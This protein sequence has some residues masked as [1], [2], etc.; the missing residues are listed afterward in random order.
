MGRNQLNIRLRFIEYAIVLL[1]FFIININSVNRADAPGG[2]ASSSPVDASQIQK[3]TSEELHTLVAP[4]ALYPD[5]LLAQILPASTFPVQIVVAYRFIQNGGKPD[6]PPADA[7][8]DSSV[9]ALLHYPTVLK[10]LNDD[11]KWT[12]QLGL[13]VTYQ[14]GDVSQ[15]IQQV[16]AE[17]SAAGNLQSNAMETTQNDGDAIEIVPAEPQLIYVPDYDPYA[18]C[19]GP[20]PN[21]FIW[22]P[23]FGFGIWLGN[24]WDWHHHHI[25]FNNYWDHGGW[26][27]NSRP[28]YWQAAT[29]PL[30][31]WYTKSGSHGLVGNRVSL[32]GFAAGA[33]ARAR[34]DPKATPHIALRPSAHVIDEEDA[35][36][37]GNQTHLESQRGQVSRNVIQQ[38][39]VEQ[40]V[41]R[42]IP[43]APQKP[44]FHEG[45]QSDR[46]TVTRESNR[47]AIS[48]GGAA[49]GGARRR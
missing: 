11:L 38:P 49:Q 45:F 43:V 23:G 47:G 2:D 4:I 48:R 5:A 42:N 29:H 1:I 28:S 35:K 44:A 33:N 30:P 18:I 25:W 24:T 8:L 41:Q 22:G 37:R 31:A 32:H 9:V 10:K 36:N 13:A 34:V 21:P 12:E 27:R 39:P 3:F 17:A 16:R 46:S 40:H 7:N 19:E 20:L 26:H 15:A 6:E 14:M